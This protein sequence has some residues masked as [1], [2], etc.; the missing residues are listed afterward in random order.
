MN[1][2][3]HDETS[4]ADIA[5]SE[6]KMAKGGDKLLFRPREVFSMTRACI[7]LKPAPMDAH[8]LT[9]DG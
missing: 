2:G 5:Y 6:N 1:W 4:E 8:L 9:N 3:D 7:A